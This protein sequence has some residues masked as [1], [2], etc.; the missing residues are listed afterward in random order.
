MTPTCSSRGCGGVLGPLRGH[1][2]R[3]DHRVRGVGPWKWVALL[4]VLFVVAHDLDT[5]RK[6][7]A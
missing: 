5:K 3:G 6:A 4:A 7:K 1:A 2:A